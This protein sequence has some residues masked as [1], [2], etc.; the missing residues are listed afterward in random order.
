MILILTGQ[1]FTSGNGQQWHL[2][3]K[4]QG[5]PGGAADKF[6]CSTS[7]AQGSPVQ[8]LGANMA[9]LGKPCCGRRPTY[10]VEEHGHG[11]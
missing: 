3:Q 2:K 1:N 9:P 5:H 10:K 4:G 11:C 8:I 6:A 7:G